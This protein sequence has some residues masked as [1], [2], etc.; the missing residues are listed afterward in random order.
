LVH[1]K[2]ECF[3]LIF[4]SSL[5]SAPLTTISFQTVPEKENGSG[6]KAQRERSERHG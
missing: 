5:V 6:A 1:L 3:Q 2:N 4:Q